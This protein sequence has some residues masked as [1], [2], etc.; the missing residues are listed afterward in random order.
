MEKKTYPPEKYQSK[1][2]KKIS[3]KN[4]TKVKSK[5]NKKTSNIT[6]I[7]DKNANK[8]IEESETKIKKFQI[9][10]INTEKKETG[11][12]NEYVHS[13]AKEASEYNLDCKKEKQNGNELT[14]IITTELTEEEKTD[15]AENII[16][17]I[18][19]DKLILLKE[20]KT[21]N[22]S[23]TLEKKKELN[24]RKYLSIDFNENVELIDNNIAIEKKDNDILVVKDKIFKKPCNIENKVLYEGKQ[25][26]EDRHKPSNYP[27]IV[28]Y[29]CINYRK[30]EKTRNSLFCNALLKRK[31]DKKSIYYILEKNH[32][33]ECLE[34]ITN[35]I[36]VE[37][38][39]I[40]TYNDYINR[41]F[42]YL[43]STEEYNKK[44]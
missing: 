40:G 31:E 21:E 22:T 27:K 34:L 36:K 38:N 5:D 17:E 15:I 8:N 35:K 11:P 39:L 3:K 23:N 16:K 28:N 2:K 13:K 32:S 19:L 18:E 44:I 33:K 43:D 41:C 4:K 1:K 9:N 20:E 30:Y 10:N 24:K 14:Q 12:Q 25:F 26:K 42:K 37:T 6:G 29:R 7:K